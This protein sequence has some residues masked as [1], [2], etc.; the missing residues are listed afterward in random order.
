MTKYELTYLITPEASEQDLT[1]IDQ[2][3]GGFIAEQG[4]TIEKTERPK[5]IELSYP[6]KE[7]QEALLAV[8]IFSLEP[9]KLA[10]FEKNIKAGSKILRYIL[11]IKKDPKKV[12][13][14]VYKK[15]VITEVT[16]E[17]IPTIEEK[18][19]ELKE[20]DQKI[21]EILKD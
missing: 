20:I 11:S 7:K 2:K 6:I 1:T 10:S 9:D 14:R 12:T 5:R 4:G 18:K 21:E 19:V 15:P 16:E 8:I 17:K 3:I 13:E